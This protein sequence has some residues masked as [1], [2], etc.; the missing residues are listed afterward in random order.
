MPSFEQSLS[1][2]APPDQVLAFVS[3]IRN[4]PRY[5]PTTKEAE[6]QG[7]GRVHVEGD[8]QGQHYDADGYL[9]QTDGG[10]EWGADEGYY[11]GWL[12]V[13]P[14]GPGSHVTVGI[15]LKGHPPGADPSQAPSED[16][17]NEGL[18]KGLESIRN[19]VEGSGGKEE[20]S[21]AT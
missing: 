20:P 4:L 2:Q 13:S 12:R 8:A 11:K 5:V 14:D 3:D 16:D 15:E 19:Q 21:A 18:R 6:P 7:E 17:I 9:R 1:M 10:L